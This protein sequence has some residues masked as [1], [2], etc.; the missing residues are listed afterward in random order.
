MTAAAKK[1]LRW[2]AAALVF[3]GA[4]VTGLWWWPQE[5]VRSEVAAAI[6]EAPALGDGQERLVDAIAAATRRALDR[7]TAT[8]G[9]GELARLYHA[10]G[11]F[12]EALSAYETLERIEPDEPRWPHLAA[13][14]LAGF[15]DFD[16]AMERWERVVALAPD[17]LPAQLRLAEGA[18]KS[19][20]PGEATQRYQQ[21]LQHWPDEPYALLGL[22]RLDFEQGKWATARPRLE[23][24]VRLTDYALGYDL[25]V[26]VYER[27][28]RQRDA[29]AVR[30]KMKASGAY[31][32]P[33][34]P[35][36][37]ALI[38]V[39]F[40]PYRIAIAAGARKD[41]EEARQ[42]LLRAIALAPDEVAYRLQLVTLY[43][44]EKNYSAALDELEEMTRRAPEF[45][46]GWARLSAL[47][48]GLGDGDGAARTLQ[49]GLKHCPD[50]PSLRLMWGS[51]LRQAGRLDEA[52]VELYR[53]IEL[54]PNE[55]AAY[56]EAAH[57][58]VARGELERGIEYLH[59]AVEA[60]PD[61]PGAL[62]FLAFHAIS[63]GNQ[64]EADRWMYRV[65]QQPRV[66]TEPA[67]RLIAAYRAKFGQ[68]FGK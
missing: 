29:D 33:P 39:C 66:E 45:A 24:V 5:R 37:D 59:R 58:H 26:N 63:T 3:A 23:Q 17:Y 22:A 2:G 10:N 19:N 16:P 56:V 53:S 65:S 34:D 14:I 4:L 42:L 61:N 7:S 41:P 38:D 1:T 64:A 51:L 67:T 49:I 20:Q 62:I 32:D 11:Y 31:R 47:R 15:G 30:A 28:G 21:I 44:D 6:P 27:L 13:L 40:D 36:L 43:T 48:K 60:E 25:I 8:E 46:D 50:S 57:V 12:Q 55:A 54:R 68:D 35:W 18:L 52:L 9:L